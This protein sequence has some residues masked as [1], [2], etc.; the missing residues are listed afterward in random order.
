LKK[1]G[2][3]E[4]AYEDTVKIVSVLSRMTNTANARPRNWL[5][6]SVR[7]VRFLREL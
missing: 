1:R 6:Y 4:F 5:L 7:N 2:D 3:G